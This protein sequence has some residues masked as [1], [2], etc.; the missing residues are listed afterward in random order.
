MHRHEFSAPLEPTR[1]NSLSKR[2]PLT[3]SAFSSPIPRIPT[4]YENPIPIIHSPGRI[5]SENV[6]RHSEH[7]V[8]FQEPEADMMSDGGR[9]I[10]NSEG[11]E[12]TAGGSK[13]RR[14]PVRTST[15]FQLAHPA[16]TLTQK[17]RLLHIRPRLLLQLQR[18]TPN[19]RPRPALDVL[20][21]TLVVPRLTNKFPRMFRGKAELGVNDVMVVKSEEYDKPDS[22][23]VDDTDSDEEGLANREVVAVICQMRKDLGGSQGKAEIVL[24]DSLWTATPLTNNIYEFVS[25]NE[26]GQKTTARWVKRSLRRSLD[27]STATSGSNDLKFTFSIMDPSSRRHPIMASLTQTTL[28]IPDHYVSVSSSAGKHP[29]TS[30]LYPLQDDTSGDEEPITQRSTHA[31]DEELKTLIQVTGIWVALRQGLSPYFKY[32]DMAC[33]A[34]AASPR[35]MSNGRVC[36]VT[37]DG[38]KPPSVD[39]SSNTPESSR[40]TFGSVGGKIRKSCSRTSPANTASSQFEQSYGPKRAASA[41]TAFMRRASA[42][43]AT[44]PLS[45]VINDG[46]EEFVLDPP[47]R[48]TTD[49]VRPPPGPLNPGGSATTIET[50]TRSQRRVQSAYIPSKTLPIELYHQSNERH[51]LDVPD[52]RQATLG[53]EKYKISR[54]RVFTNLFRRTRTDC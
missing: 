52:T 19:I 4:T 35:V 21:S 1:R 14:R 36:S 24:H 37:P 20:P 41:G 33:S 25:I 17:Q 53:G 2:S 12:M 44:N 45:T 49:T 47:R 51:S 54:W 27:L 18:L 13:G 11:S 32:N 42:R 16:P 50:P 48:A 5:L 9:S 40:S 28:N 3:R 43:R 26:Q 29:P 7:S 39:L 38:S 22:Q 15:A 31:I 23:A 10:A 34:P 46:D 30:P 6:H 8:R